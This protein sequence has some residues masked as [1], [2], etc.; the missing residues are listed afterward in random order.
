MYVL[1]PFIIIT[2]LT[3][4]LVG[5]VPVFVKGLQVPRQDACDPNPSNQSI[6]LVL[7]DHTG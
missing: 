1:L 2:R 3:F 5:V 7:D 6:G 4:I